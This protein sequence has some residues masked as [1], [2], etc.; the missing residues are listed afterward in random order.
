MA[1]TIILGWGMHGGL[2]DRDRAVLRLL[3]PHQHKLFCLGR[4]EKTQQP[5]HPLYLK[6][7]TERIPVFTSS[8]FLPV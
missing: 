4:T 1:H 2:L 3:A 5:K 8:S 7:N 6:L